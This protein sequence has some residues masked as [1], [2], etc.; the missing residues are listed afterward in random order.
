MKYVDGKIALPK[1]PGLGVEL[2]R[3]KLDEYAA[4][5]RQTGGY[6]YD[7]DPERPEWFAITPESRFAAPRSAGARPARKQTKRHS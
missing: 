1:G 5:Y 7:R 2:D 4:L 3:A 6:P